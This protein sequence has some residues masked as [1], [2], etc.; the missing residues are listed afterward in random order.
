MLLAREL[1]PAAFGVFAAALSMVT[2]VAPLASFGVGGFWLKVFGEEGWQ[3]IRWLRGS[4][5]FTVATTLLVLAAL[6]IWAMLG[7]HDVITSG[8]LIVLSTYLVGQVAVE[9]VSA[10]LQLEERYA[11]LAVWQLLPHLLRLLLIA[12]LALVVK[13]TTLYS[14]AYAYALIAVGVFSIGGLLMYRM[15]CGEFALKGHGDMSSSTCKLIPP[16]SIGQVAAQ[17]WSFGLSGVLY[18]IYFQSD[19]VLLKYMSGDMAAGVYNVAFVI[20][21]AVYMLPSVVYQK[22][23]LPKIHRW[24]H[25][26]RRKFY[27]VY[28]VGNIAMLVLGVLAMLVIWVLAPWA[29]PFL[30]GVHYE[31]AILVILILGVAAPARFFA[32][33]AGAIL[34]TQNHIVNKNYILIAVAVVNVGLNIILIPAYSFVG[35]ALSTVVAEIILAIM[36]HV[37]IR[38]RVFAGFNGEG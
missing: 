38:H 4:L 25:Q 36:L 26:D 23:L 13:Q 7:P 18:L 14:A 16:S 3:A 19:I 2:L 31:D 15:Y 22:Y 20:M 32:S 6:S 37:Y 8:L 1:G 11:G 9:L 27:Q 29:I 12:M 5:A 24:S 35:A 21:A 30:F 33:S 34:S 17:S 10:K 28:R